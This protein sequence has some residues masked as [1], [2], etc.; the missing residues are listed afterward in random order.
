[1]M[2]TLIIL[3]VALTLSACSPVLNRELMQQGA[4]DVRLDQLRATPDVYKG[5]LYIF[6]GLV[7]NTRLTE[8]GSQVE[9]L[10]APVDS[11][12]YL[13]ESGRAQ[14][15][16]LALYPKEKGLLDPYVYRKGREITL[17]GVFLEARKGRIDEMEYVYPVFEIREIYLWS[18]YRNYPSPYYPYYPYYNYPFPYDPW[19]WPHPYWSPAW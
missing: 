8:T 1:M 7:V 13:E 9:A 6:G 5:R 11:L 12:G 3:S 15:R 2:N 14:G 17:A 4:R 16:F 19:G 10:F 18:E